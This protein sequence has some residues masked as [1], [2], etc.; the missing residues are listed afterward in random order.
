LGIGYWVL[1]EWESGEMVIE[2]KM[3][4]PLWK[5]V[6]ERR[7][8]LEVEDGATVADALARLRAAY[9]Q[10]GAALDAG[11]TRM[12]IPFNFFVN[13][14][15]V[16]EREL[17]QRKLKAGDTL[18]ILAPIVGGSGRNNGSILA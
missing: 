17:A 2:V 9:P 12:G 7:V 1:G 6:G 11:G 15:L 14:R 4:E 3:G 13:R 5:A 8:A 16:K 10:F 18:H